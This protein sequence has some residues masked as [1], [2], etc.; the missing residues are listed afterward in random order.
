M[1]HK[2]LAKDFKDLHENTNI[3][4]YFV[5]N[6]NEM[7][8]INTIIIGPKNTPYEGGFFWIQLKPSERYPFDSPSGKFMSPVP[9]LRVH[10]NLYCCGKICLSIL[11]TWSG[12]PWTPAMNFTTIILSIQ[13]I[14]CDNPITNEPGCGKYDKNSSMSTSYNK[15][16]KYTTLKMII[17]FLSK[18]YNISNFLQ[19]KINNH[20]ISNLSYYNNLF[21]DA[22]NYGNFIE[23]D[24]T[25][26]GFR[27]VKLDFIK[28][29]Q[30]WKFVT[31]KYNNL[32]H[33]VR[34]LFKELKKIKV[35]SLEIDF[36]DLK[37]IKN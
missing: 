2:R 13:S 8:T 10:P 11:G 16:V 9:N 17:N 20:V 25:Y 21:N 24:C 23:N 36:I 18:H 34:K 29:H 30:E 12:P 35:D 14:L 28:L 4:N 19:N 33:H 32:K 7:S 22:L 15:I 3:Q 6:S 27:N 5:D 37:N 1:T 31:N 26:Y